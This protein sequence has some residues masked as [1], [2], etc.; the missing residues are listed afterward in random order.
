MAREIEK[1]TG[2]TK[3]KI[4][5]DKLRYWANSRSK[6]LS[7]LEEISLFQWGFSSAGV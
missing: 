4:V 3:L 6:F 1:V 7:I 2:N 5:N